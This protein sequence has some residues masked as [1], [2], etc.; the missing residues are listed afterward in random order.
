MNKDV[1]KLVSPTLEYK[2]QVMNLK[3]I[4]LNN[5]EHFDGCSGLEECETYEEWLNFDERL[6]KKY[7]DSYV[8]SNVYLGIRERDN[9]LVGIIDIRHY[10]SEFL[11]NYGGHI[12]YSVLPTERRKGYA[13]EMLRMAV[14]KC[15]SI[16]TR[17]ILLSCDKENIASIKTI[18]ANGGV[19]ENEV[20]DEVGLTDSGII[21]RY[22]IN[23]KKRYADKTVKNRVEEVI[24]KTITVNEKLFTGDIY[25]YDFIKVKTKIVVSDEICILDNGYKWLEF[26]NYDSKIKLT[27]I[28]DNNLEI[29]EWYF[30]IAKEIGK[31]NGL[32]YEDDLY[33]DVVVTSDEKIQLIDED[34]LEDALK[35]M[36]INLE[37][38]KLAYDEA[39]KLISMLDGNTNK[40]AIFT[41]EYLDKMI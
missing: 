33:L 2:E 19:L 29:V 40:L 26:Y 8:P 41:K 36:E 15:Q 11:Y 17:R 5:D 9:K 3:N 25:F 39:K 38:Y 31:D 27:A 35:R 6:K 22:W 1:L 12:G 37:E 21:Q 30:D 10:L 24:Q 23:K 16:N 32:P 34:D 14:D 13:K 28:Y 7:G 20:K 4:L 18:M